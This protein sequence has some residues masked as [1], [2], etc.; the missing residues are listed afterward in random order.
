MESVIAKRLPELIDLQNLIEKVKAHGAR[1]QVL[2]EVPYKQH[3]FPIYAIEMG[4]DDV[5]APCLTIV[6]GVH[7]LERI[8]TLMALSSLQTVAELLSWDNT[9]RERLE[10]S[11]LIYIPLINPVGMFRRSRSNGNN[12]DL[13]RNAPVYSEEAPKFLYGGHRIS[14]KIPF[15][16]GALTDGM[17][18]E[19]QVLCDFI[20]QRVFPAELAICLDIHSGF[21]TSDRLWFPYARTKKPFPFFVEAYAFRELLNKSYPHNFYA[22]EPQSVQ[23]TTHGDV[24]DYLFDRQH[25]SRPNGE[26]FLPLTLEMGSWKWVRKNPKQ[27]FDLLG[28][29]NPILPHRRA[30]VLRDHKT[31]IDFL[32]RAVMSNE[33]I[34][35]PKEQK[36]ILRFEALNLWYGG[37]AHGL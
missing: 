20:E 27:I 25:S 31:F 28:V 36:A 16:R 34:N 29:Y 30:R 7:G 22:I 6:G 1:V 32:H 33:W 13:M 10:K 3:I 8:G 17:E 15:Y 21:G 2:A 23:Y 19:N 4:V 35:L 5:T 37:N 18:L 26:F 24:W 9:L 12:V 11:R 14:P